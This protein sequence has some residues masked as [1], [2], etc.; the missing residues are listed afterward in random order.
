MGIFFDCTFI[1]SVLE[2]RYQQ[3]ESL[4]QIFHLEHFHALLEGQ[5]D[6][7]RDHTVGVLDVVVRVG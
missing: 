7:L 6:L 2:P 5:V 1:S 4:A 3:E